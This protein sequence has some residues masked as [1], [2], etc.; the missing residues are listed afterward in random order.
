MGLKDDLKSIKTEFSNDEKMLENAFRLEILLKRYKKYLIALA[1]V[2]IVAIAYIFI[3]DSV[4][5]ANALK[6]TSAYEKL[7]NNPDDEKALQELESSSKS[8]YEAYLFFHHN[9]LDLKDIQNDFIK[10][11]AHYQNASIKAGDTLDSNVDSNALN[12]A[13]QNLESSDGILRHYGLL[14]VA[15][16]LLQ[17]N[18]IEQAKAKLALIPSNSPLRDEAN[19]L[20][21]F[22]LTK[23]TQN[24]ESKE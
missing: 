14:Q 2:L 24:A 20:E 3:S 21:H 8:L 16:V 15:F 17:Q 6:A 18:E 1:V 10:A 23:A 5:K 13:L 19:L 7:L 12:Q 9:K 11:L 4:K 22:M